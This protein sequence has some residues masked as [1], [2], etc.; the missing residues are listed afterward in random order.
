MKET[1]FTAT[2]IAL[3]AKMADFA[4]FNM[5]IQ[6]PTGINREHMIVREGVGV[7][8]VS[9]MGEFWVKGEKALDFLQYIT[10]ND[11]SK[12]EAGKAQYTCFPNGRGGIVDDFIVYMY[13][14]TKYLLVVNAGNIDKDWAWVNKQNTERFNVQLENA[15]DQYGQLA[16]Q[17]PKATEML[18][19]LTDAE[20]SAIP[21][22]CFR[23]WS[24]AGVQGVILSNTGY[25]GAG[26]F[27]LYFKKEYGKQIWDALF[28]VGKDYGLAPIGLGARDSLRLE[29]WFCLYGH[30]IDD[31]HSPIEAGLGWITKFDAKDF[32]DKE[33]LLKQKQEGVQRKLV[34]F[35]MQE[36]AIPRNGY[37]IC[38]AEGNVIGNV[39][40]GIMLP[41]TKQGIGMGYVKT[42][43]SKKDTTIYVKI[44]EKLCEAKIV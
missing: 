10:T 4:G 15:S 12:L 27:E 6:Y 26:G 40:S 9:H 14:T 34:H 21:Y 17:G 11:V 20:L 38:D 41:T 8:D 19:K 30:D 32:I 25:T 16:V 18:Q 5:P 13:S 36:R 3:G 24:F 44:R 42:A 29:K 7:F 33:F 35:V 28:E 2:H 23:E 22:Y 43:F 1:P 39:T 31:E 37:E